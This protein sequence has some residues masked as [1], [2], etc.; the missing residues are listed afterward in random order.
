MKRAVSKFMGIISQFLLKALCV[1]NNDALLWLERL[2]NLGLTYKVVIKLLSILHVAPMFYTFSLSGRLVCIPTFLY[3]EP[4][5]EKIFTPKQGEVVVDVGAYVG[6]YSLIASKYVGKDGIVIA[7]EAHPANYQVLLK[8]ITLNKMENIIPINKA[9]LNRNGTCEL[10][11]GDREGWHSIVKK[12]ERSIKVPCITL[13]KLLEKLGVTQVNWIKIDVEGAE[14]KVLQGMKRILKKSQ[15][16]TLLIEL[17]K[18]TS[19]DMYNK[20]I[21]IGFNIGSFAIIDSQHIYASNV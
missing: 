2:A 3:S 7:V 21:N 15:H 10:F 16:L 9:L 11:I 1:I 5:V 17:H 19:Q 13:D 12:T 8:N 18:R 20:L 4:E 14:Y 6:R